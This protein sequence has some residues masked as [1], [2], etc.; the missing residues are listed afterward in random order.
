MRKHIYVFSNDFIIIIMEIW[1]IVYE[2]M[3]FMFP[4]NF[5]NFF[6][7]DFRY[8]FVTNEQELP[9]N[10]FD[11]IFIGIF[12]TDLI[13]KFVSKIN[14]N[15]PIYS[16]STCDLTNFSVKPLVI[17]TDDNFFVEISNDILFG[18][19]QEMALP[20]ESI[21][22][23]DYDNKV[24]ACLDENTKVSYLSNARPGA[25]LPCYG[26]EKNTQWRKEKINVL[27]FSN[28]ALREAL[29]E[30]GQLFITNDK[31]ITTEKNFYAGYDAFKI[32]IDF[33][34]KLALAGLVNN[35]GE[36]EINNGKTAYM[37]LE[38]LIIKM[39]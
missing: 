9:H 17:K 23:Y 3:D 30:K 18:K 27:N 2:K 19:V 15:C 1:L 16:V 4:Y 24:K 5:S 39:G 34:I 10:K 26:I 22:S 35:Q 8:I 28:L 37:L 6:S 12:D 32:N 31:Y 7:L 20:I 29:K 33:D 13:I 38:K 21:S 14:K 25:Y 11:K 36:L